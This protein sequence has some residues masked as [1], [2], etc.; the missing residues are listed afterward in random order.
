[1]IE[2]IKNGIVM[3]MKNEKKR[4]VFCNECKYYQ[5]NNGGYPHELCKWRE[6]ETP[7]KDD[8][9]SSGERINDEPATDVQEVKHGRWIGKPISGYS[10]CK[11]SVCNAVFNINFCNGTSWYKYCP[12]CGAKMDDDKNERE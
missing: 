6:D 8:F 4:I 7:D 2:N 5:D 9:C 3:D 10:D 11:C 12:K 1:M